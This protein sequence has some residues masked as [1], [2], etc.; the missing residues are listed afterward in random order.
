MS[1]Q[2]D[3]SEQGVKYGI[4]FVESARRPLRNGRLGRRGILGAAPASARAR[5]ERLLRK[6]NPR[7]ASWDVFVEKFE[8]FTHLLCSAAQYGA[9]STIEL[10]YLA[11]RA[12]FLAH[13][14]DHAPTI[15][16]SLGEDAALVYDVAADASCQM[17]RF[18]AV[19]LPRTIQE[20]LAHD[21]GTLISLISRISQAV[22]SVDPVA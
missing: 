16:A 17:D 9:T 18:E 7:S 8:K 5:R 22:Y 10:E 6:A 2:G 21:D 3:I 15:R 12:W 14:Y 4:S 1:E 19:F 20:L 13:Y 11:L